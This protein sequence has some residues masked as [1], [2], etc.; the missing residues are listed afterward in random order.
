MNIIPTPKFVQPQIGAA[1]VITIEPYIMMN[2]LFEDAIYSFKQY[3][4]RLYDTTIK[5]MPAAPISV[6]LE[7]ILEPGAYR[8]SIGENKVVIAA[9]DNVG[10]NHAFATILQ[11]MKVDN[12]NIM[13]PAI[14]VRDKP[15][16][17]YRG[18]MVDIAR[19]W[20]PFSYL[21]SYVDMCY[22]YKVSVLHL[23]FTD[24]QSYTLPSDVYPKL[25][26]ENR[27]YT[28]QEIQELVQYAKVR[29]VEIMPEIDVPGHCKSF[30]ES[31]GEL[32]GT[33]GVI[34]PYTES[35]SALRKLFCELCDMFPY[36]KYIHIGGDEVYAM[37]EWQKSSRCCEYAKSIGIDSDVHLMYVHFLS[38]MADV[39]IKKGKQPIV[40]EG[41]A[42]EYNDKI[43]KN[44][45]VMAWESYY[46][47]APELLDAGFKVINCSWNPMYIV[48]PEPVWEPREVFD[49]SIY[50]WRG[51]HPESPYLNRYY[52]SQPDAQI[53]GGEL[54][55]WGDFV[56]SR[57][58]SVSEGITKERE[59]LLE[60]IP[61]LAENTWNVEKIT[62]YTEFECS[63]MLLNNI[64]S[65][66]WC[67]KKD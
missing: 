36:S 20:H 47:L 35:M 37:D 18:M 54:L 6:V 58:S 12:G 50:R 52:E 30:G 60:R 1:N 55:A 14:A 15:D 39:C 28:K 40:W 27:H 31:Y 65:G 56:S 44:I 57:F 63:V 29:G 17:K 43:S 42:K 13:L 34:E 62:E 48:V 26:T 33:K 11:I 61:M 5:E 23:H 32:F 67:N 16:C 8:I 66:L 24:D 53:I 19:A 51:I 46:Q 64:L 7:N 4:K 49:W 9:S 59:S 38:E 22:Y 45:I 25:S 3:V 2:N 21:L 41:F 10:A